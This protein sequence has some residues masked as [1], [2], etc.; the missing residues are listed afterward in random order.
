MKKET[1]YKIIFVLMI[2]S[3]VA[4]IILSFVPIE[5]ACGG[6][7]ELLGG[8]NVVQASQYESIF[9]M[10]NAHIGLIAFPVLA[11]LTLFELKKPRRYQKKAITIGMAIGSLIA[12]Y[13]L[14]I[15]FFVLEA[16]CQYCMIVD[17]A[18]LISLGLIIFWDEK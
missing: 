14:Y 4:S 9:G 8:C 13:F 10:K 18:V 1:K 3:L 15:Q 7:L 12:I 11:I 2:L 6:A 17:F 5:Q 16:I